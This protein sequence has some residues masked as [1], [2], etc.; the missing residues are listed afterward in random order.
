MYAIFESGG[1]QYR[2]EAG[3]VISVDLLSEEQGANISFGQVLFVDDGEKQHVGAP[4]CNFTVKAE[5]LGTVAGPKVRGL[6]YKKRKQE[7][8]RWGHRQHYT[9]VKIVGI[10]SNQG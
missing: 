3:D 5:I 7:Q 8:R 1:K 10:N 4:S 2:V 9:Q 6:K